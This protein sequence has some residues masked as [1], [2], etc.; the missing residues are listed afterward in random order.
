MTLFID[1][2]ATAPALTLI[3]TVAVIGV[4]HTIVPDHWVPITLIARER[5]WSKAETAKAAGIAGTGHVITTLLLGI[6]VW[7]AGAVVAARFGQVVD[8]I[9]SLALIGFGLWVATS[10]WLEI[11]HERIHH[12]DH[13]MD[14]DHDHTHGAKKKRTALLLILGSSPMIEGIPAFFAA[15]KF[16]VGVI[17]V[18][19]V[20]FAIS[21][22]VTYVLLCT[23]SYAGIENMRLGTFEKYGEVLSGVFITIIGLVFFILPVF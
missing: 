21:T 12:H 9:S 19:A 15:G 7:V 11:R 2:L 20:V 16:G 18:M 8:L 10:S 1:S 17:I 6:V 5:K 23:L 13:G 4:L 3:A 22:I 14:H